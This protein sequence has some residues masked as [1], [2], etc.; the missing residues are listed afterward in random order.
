MAERLI[1]I[2]NKLGLHARA[3]AKLATKAGSFDCE[4]MLIKGEIEVNAKSIMGIMMLAACKGTELG[5][6]AEGKDADAALDA[7]ETLVNN[8]F[9]E[10]Q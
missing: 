9:G 10:E 6:R 2:Q 1:R 3:S 7:I 5:L 8:R 4:V